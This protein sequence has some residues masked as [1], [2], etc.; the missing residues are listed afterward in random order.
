MR[1]TSAI[2]DV[3]TQCAR[4]V[5]SS[6]LDIPIRPCRDSDG[7]AGTQ[8]GCARG[9]RPQHRARGPTAAFRQPCARRKGSAA[10]GVGEGEDGVPATHRVRFTGLRRG[11]DGPRDNCTLSRRRYGRFAGVDALGRGS[12]TPLGRRGARG[13]QAA[14]SEPAKRVQNDKP[15][16]RGRRW[17]IGLL[18]ECMARH[19]GTTGTP[20]NRLR[21]WACG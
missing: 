7:T 9:L 3:G 14:G 10:T 6:I 2:L 1:H 13:G 16:P 4:W 8:L 21:P 18:Q 20:R 12:C 5:Q 17:T 15:A 19:Q 11:R